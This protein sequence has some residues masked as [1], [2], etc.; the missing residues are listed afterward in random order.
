MAQKVV[1]PI[2]ITRTKSL[3]VGEERKQEELARDVIRRFLIQPSAGSDATSE[4][5]VSD[6][7]PIIP[8]LDGELAVESESN[9]L[10]VCR[11]SPSLPNTSTPCTSAK[12]TRLGFAPRAPL[13]PIQSPSVDPSH[14]QEED[15]AL[16][17]GES[18]ATFTRDT[19]FRHSAVVLPSSSSVWRLA[20]EGHHAVPTSQSE[21]AVSACVRAYVP[22]HVVMH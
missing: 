22:M 1:R 15:S 19:P 8:S 18:P 16:D 13:S 3:K 7:V 12:P 20:D 17:V 21:A 10:T 9:P 4:D 14:S 6:D 11:S 2:P 5:E